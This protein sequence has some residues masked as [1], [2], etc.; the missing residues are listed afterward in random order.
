MSFGS[1]EA[2][3]PFVVNSNALLM[4]ECAYDIVKSLEFVCVKC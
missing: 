4:L 2:I 1:S 3:S